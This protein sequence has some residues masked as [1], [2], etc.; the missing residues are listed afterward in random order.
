MIISLTR[1][2]TT[3]IDSCDADLSALKWCASFHPKSPAT[4]STN[5]IIDERSPTE[6]K[7]DGLSSDKQYEGRRFNYGSH[8][9]QSS[10]RVFCAEKK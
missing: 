7:S 6:L 2:Q 8:T 1:N 5:L 10:R 3:T 9:L 4:A